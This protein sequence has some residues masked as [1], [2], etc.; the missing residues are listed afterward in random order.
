MSREE[1]NAILDRFEAQLNADPELAQ[2][3]A[4]IMPYR[5]MAG[6]PAG[7]VGTLDA[8]AARWSAAR[9]STDLQEVSSA[10]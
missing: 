2:L 5:H 4:L 9:G 8:L 10:S 3:G 7:L 1:A 6:D